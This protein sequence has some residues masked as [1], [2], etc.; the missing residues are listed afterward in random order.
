MK[1]VSCAAASRKSRLTG[2]NKACFTSGRPSAHILGVSS[3]GTRLNRVGI[4]HA[5]ARALTRWDRSSTDPLTRISCVVLII[6]EAEACLE[7]VDII[8]RRRDETEDWHNL[9]V[10]PA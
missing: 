2:M 8:T 6:V 5:T 10:L 9:Q 3:H 4:A 1:V 7:I